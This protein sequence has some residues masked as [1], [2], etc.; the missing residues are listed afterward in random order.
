MSEPRA[1]RVALPRGDLRTPVAER[2]RAARFIV[3]GYGEGSRSYRFEVGGIPGVQV[4]VFSDEDIPIQVALG[5]YDLGIASRTRIDELLLRFPKDS[6]VPLHRLDLEGETLVAAGAPGTTFAGLAAGGVVRVATEFS[7]IAQHYLTRLRVPDYRLYEVWAQ[8]EAWPPEDAEVAIASASAAEREGLSI[9]GEVHRGGVWLIANRDALA[10]RDLSAALGPLVSLPG[11]DERVGVVV[12][13][14]LTGL[15]R[16]VPRAAAE[17]EAFRLA[18]PDGHAQRHTVEALAAAGIAFAGY[19]EGRAL[20]HPVSA[21]PEV[22]VKVM[23]PQDM[24]R[25]VALGH[26]DLALTGR[27]WLRTFTA[28]FPAAPIVELCDLKRSKYRMGAVISEDLPVESIEE[29]VALWRTGDPDRPIR[30]AS[31][32]ASLA[33]EY[34]RSRHL[35]QYRVIPISGASEGFVPEDAEILIEG[36]ETGSTLR[37]NRLRMIDVIM[38]STNCAIGAATRPPGRRGALRDRYVQ[39]L[40][41]AAAAAE[42]SR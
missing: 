22:V 17:R 16:A 14:P 4:R 20:R 28:S 21:D 2:L 8:A 13:A 1:I 24:P 42:E 6:I 40:A 10:H 15:R 26:F 23:R 3:E 27:D 38:E 35:R 34:A 25:A 18:V 30:V 19:E 12:P 9:L 29:A 33:D 7:N 37:A 39:Q 41:A 32:Y 36:T 11:G 31:E 5:H